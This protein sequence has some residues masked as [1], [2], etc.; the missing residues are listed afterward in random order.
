METNPWRMYQ[1]SNA[2]IW[3]FVYRLVSGEFTFSIVPEL[4]RFALPLTD[5]SRC[6]ALQLGNQIS[7]HF[8]EIIQAKYKV[9][10]STVQMT[11]KSQFL[12]VYVD[13]KGWHGCT[14]EA[15]NCWTQTVPLGLF[16]ATT[17]RTRILDKIRFG[18]YPSIQSKHYIMFNVVLLPH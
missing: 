16:S 9:E 4:Q 15:G 6:R 3:A 10:N 17:F 18:E 14:I 12:L 13:R 5:S 8:S 1:A 7:K 2:C 11:G